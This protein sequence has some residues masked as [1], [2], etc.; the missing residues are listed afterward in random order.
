MGIN[1]KTLAEFIISLH[2]QTSSPEEFKKIIA[3]HG[4]D[5]PDPP[6]TTIDRLVLTMHAEHKNKRSKGSVGGGGEEG[7]KKGMD[8][9]TKARAFKG[10]ALPDKEVPPAW[11]GDYGE[12]EEKRKRKREPNALDDMMAMLENLE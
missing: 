2:Q 5:Y 8:Q 4:V 6:I 9:D 7:A 1:D 11:E 10:L 12:E 3:L